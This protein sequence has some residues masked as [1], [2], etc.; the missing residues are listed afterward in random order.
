MMKFYNL[1][2]KILTAIQILSMVYPVI[3]LPSASAS[4][5]TV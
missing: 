4:A 5:P 1:R 2:T 3:A